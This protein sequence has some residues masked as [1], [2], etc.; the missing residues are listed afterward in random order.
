MPTSAFAPPRKTMTA[1]P[2]PQA[3]TWITT[4]TARPLTASLIWTNISKDRFS[5]YQ[6]FFNALQPTANGNIVVEGSSDNGANYGALWTGS[7]HSGTTAVNWSTEG[8]SAT[9]ILFGSAQGIDNYPYTARAGVSGTLLLTFSP[10]GSQTQQ[11]NQLIDPAQ[12]GGVLFGYDSVG[13]VHK[14]KS[15]AAYYAIATV[16]EQLNTLRFTAVGGTGTLNRG[17]ISI[18]G[19]TI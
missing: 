14:A 17:S 8:A 4:L 13:S 18:Y 2:G 1:A 7:Y 10:E 12:I 16:G 9:H 19:V 11:I 3:L 5:T 6:L 15:N